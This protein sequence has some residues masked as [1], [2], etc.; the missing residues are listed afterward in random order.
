MN[1]RCKQ[2]GLVSRAGIQHAFLDPQM[3]CELWLV[4]PDLL[5]EALGVLAPDEYV[6]RISE[7][8]RRGE[9]FVD[10]G[11]DE[12][13]WRMASPHGPVQMARRDTS[14]DSVTLA[15]RSVTA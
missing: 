1:R 5:D 7:R 9:R 2:A 13:A 10:H 8:A 14:T 11:V 6:D 15:R 3:P 4:A 12:H